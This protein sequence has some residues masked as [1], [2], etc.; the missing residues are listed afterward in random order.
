M[1]KFDDSECENIFNDIRNFFVSPNI[2]VVQC[3]AHSL[4][5][6]IKDFFDEYHYN[7]VF[8]KTRRAVYKL[9]SVELSS[10]LQSENLPKPSL[11]NNTRWNST[12]SM[13]ADLL[14]LKPFIQ[15]HE[16]EHS[17]LYIS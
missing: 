6:S 1:D 3:N 15:N 5:L 10:K 11:A 12:Y 8:E 7:E 9:R 2:E 4:Q 13:L 17:E 16:L 14:L